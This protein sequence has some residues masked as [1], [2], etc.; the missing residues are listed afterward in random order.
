MEFL[1]PLITLWAAQ[2]LAVIS[3]GQ[4]FVLI[5]KLALSNPRPVAMAA[6]IGLGAGTIVWSSAAIGGLAI[7]LEHAAW[8]YTAFKIA[9]GVYL[10]FLAIMLWRHA[11][12]P[13]VL[14]PAKQK[15]MGARNAFMMGL[16][17]QL[18]N[19]KVIVFFGSIFVALLP[20]HSPSWVY[21]VAVII[22]FGNE[23]G[24]YAVVAILFSVKHSRNA[25][26]RA[27]TW[28]DR[29]MG[30]FLSLIGVRLIIDA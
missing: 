22:V 12:D 8:A 25:Y 24:W 23:I 20:A 1:L 11:R 14:D 5:S 16:A 19:P 17:T 13:V 3:P 29:V 28:I 15:Q 10:L 6:V 18:A 30:G 26:I 7:V 2:L 21:V 9:G 4:S 27:K